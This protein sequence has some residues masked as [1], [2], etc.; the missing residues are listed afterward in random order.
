[1]NY[2]EKLKTELREA[3][4]KFEELRGFQIEKTLTKDQD[5]E[6]RDLFSA[7]KDLN[8][9]LDTEMEESTLLATLSE[10]LE[11]PPKGDKVEMRS[12]IEITEQPVYATFGEQVQ[13]I[14][15]LGTPGASS[16]EARSRLQ[17]AEKQINAE[18]RAA[19]VGQV[20]GVGTDGGAFVQ[21]D[22]AT[23]LFQKGFNNGSILPKTQKRKLSGNSN[24]V[25]IMGID[26]TS[27]AAGSRNGGVRVYTKAE[28]EQYTSSKASFNGIEIKVNKITGM[29]F[30]AD[31][32]LEDASFLQGEVEDLFVAEFDF[33][34]QDLL[35]HGLGAGEPL[36]V[37][38]CDALVAVAKEGSQPADTIVTANI[39]KMKAR[40]A[41][42][43][44]EFYA[45]R[46]TIPQLDALYRTVGSNNVTPLFKQTS[47]YAGVLDGIPITFVEQA[48]TLGDKG[49]IALIDWSQYV[50]A[51]KGTLN[52]Q[53][54]FHLKFDYGQKAIRWTMRF[55]GQ[56][57]WKS[58]LTPY[59]GSATTS[60]FVVLAARA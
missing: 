13:D 2:I 35:F 18:Q 59:K 15:I 10:P 52:K 60:P 8:A 44:A 6:K 24:S 56:P 4:A 26:E 49:D 28:L 16:S 5:T 31:E 45:N 20:S 14:M 43:R 22:F 58:A 33:K 51:T 9:K 46:D 57:R 55:D 41:G 53:E 42:S 7:I 3:V 1:M 54:S 19:G 23:D 39:S 50:T 40:V 11:A 48:E 25:E 37:M 47:I 29:L 17:K 34:L 30:L 36:G 27:R 38:A 12:R 21:T 32:I